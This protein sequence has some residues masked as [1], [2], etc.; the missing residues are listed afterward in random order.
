L[1]IALSIGKVSVA[2]KMVRVD[3]LDR[4]N[5]VL[6]QEKDPSMQCICRRSSPGTTIR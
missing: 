2:P 3:F 4:F 1:N 6:E 5:M